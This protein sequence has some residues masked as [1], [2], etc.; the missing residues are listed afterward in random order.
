MFENW[1]VACG[2]RVRAG[3]REENVRRLFA[4]RP[5]V[6]GFLRGAALHVRRTPRCGRAVPVHVRIGTCK[7]PDKKRGGENRSILVSNP[8]CRQV[9]SPIDG[10]EHS[11]SDEHEPS[12]VCFQEYW[13]YSDSGNKS[14]VSIFQRDHIPGARCRF[15]FPADL[16]LQPAAAL[17]C[18]LLFRYTL[19]EGGLPFGD[20]PESLCAGTVQRYMGSLSNRNGTLLYDNCFTGRTARALLRGLPELPSRDLR[21]QIRAE[22]VFRTRS[23]S[24]ASVLKRSIS[25]RSTL[26]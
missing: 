19:R 13:R 15:G 14:S 1:A 3:L 21:P 9:T 25:P 26:P 5:F 4:V 17:G 11:T 2:S 8:G 23:Q 20:G 22:P 18:R 12:S 7:C 6:S 16:S 10:H 24:A